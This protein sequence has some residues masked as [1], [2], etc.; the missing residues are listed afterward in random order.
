MRTRGVRPRRD[1]RLERDRFS[2]LFMEE[3]LDRPRNVPLRSPAEA[4]GGEPLEHAVSDLAGLLDRRQLAFVFDGA[5]AL[6]ERAPR[7]RLD[8][9]RGE[10]GM[11]RVADEVGLEADRA[12]EL[13]GQVLQD[14]ALRLLELDA[15]DRT[16]GFGVAKVG[17][18]PHTL[19]V[20]EQ[21][22]VRAREPGE[23]ED[24]RRIGDKQWLLERRAQA[25]DAS[26][27]RA[28]PTRST[29]NSS[30]SL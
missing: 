22:G 5:Q 18:Q 29:M 8:A 10:G 19:L 25:L 12:G 11:A 4:L 21:R 13:R 16:G 26:A 14:R 23:V 15:V 7:N 27:H 3:L 24:V 17:E 28:A 9:V 6:D 30:P 2:S 20:D 1:D